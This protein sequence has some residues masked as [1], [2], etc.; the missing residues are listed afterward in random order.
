ME[1]TG[2]V[3]AVQEEMDGQIPIACAGYVGHQDLKTCPADILM[4]MNL[5]LLN[6][7]VMDK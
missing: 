1:D 6:M 5:F 4:A 2:E 3:F 7:Q